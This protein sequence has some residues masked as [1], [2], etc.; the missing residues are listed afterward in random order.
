MNKGKDSLI[1]EVVPDSDSGEL[2]G[3]VGIMKINIEEGQHYYEFEY[4][5]K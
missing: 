5:F 4:D 2:V 1:L 3:L